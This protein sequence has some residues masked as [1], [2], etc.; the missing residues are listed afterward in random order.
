[1]SIATE[2]FVYHD[3]YRPRFNIPAS[4]YLLYN[5]TTKLELFLQNNAR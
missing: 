3:G 5:I 2:L 1:M 4:G